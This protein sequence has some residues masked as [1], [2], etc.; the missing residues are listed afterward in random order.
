MTRRFS[1]TLLLDSR[2]S[3]ICHWIFPIPPKKTVIVVGAGASR[4]AGLPTNDE[5]KKIIA[6]DLDI[7]FDF[8]QFSGDRTIAA[9]L[10]V[11]GGINLYL[12]ACWRIRDA[13]PQAMSIDNF[14]DAHQGNREIELSGKLGIVKSIL[15]AERKSRLYVDQRN[16]NNNFNFGSVERTW[17]NAFWQRIPENCQAE[18][19]GER[20]S[21][22][23]LVVFNYDRCIEHFL[24]QSIQ[25]YYGLRPEEAASLI[26][27]MEIYHP[28]GMVGSLPWAGGLDRI[29]FG[30]MPN[31][32]S[33]VKIA[34][35]IKTF[36]EGTDPNASNV[37]K[38]RNHVK[39]AD[40]LVFLG[41]AYHRQNLELLRLSNQRT[42]RAIRCYGTTFGISDADLEEIMSEL[43]DLC[44]AWLVRNE[45]KNLT[46]GDFFN[47][48]RK[49]L[50]FV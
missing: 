1:T 44:G 22:V 8:Q 20:L 39:T 49:A 18:G 16:M 35:Q 5:L 23:V 42:K 11:C 33:L 2:Y 3:N 4:E 32:Q 7:K 48:Y 26:T 37:E 12:P 47:T 21:S 13:L 14:I 43:Q 24:Y 45:E 9:A 31:S 25:N 30:A 38:I 40:R 15:Q 6:Q 50:S 19:L 34:A 10:D 28:Y 46:C 36:T 27:A 41:F 17:F 29:E